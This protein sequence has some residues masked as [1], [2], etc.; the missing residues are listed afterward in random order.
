MRRRRPTSKVR[1]FTKS[2]VRHQLVDVDAGMEIEV[3]LGGVENLDALLTGDAA[4]ALLHVR[5]QGMVAVPFRAPNFEIEIN[6]LSEGQPPVGIP[7]PHEGHV[8]A[9]LVLVVGRQLQGGVEIG[10]RGQGQVERVFLARL[11]QPCQQRLLL[12]D[13]EH[14]VMG[15]EAL[16]VRKEPEILH[17]PHG[18]AHIV[19]AQPLERGN[20]QGRL[21]L[22]QDQVGLECV[23]LGQ[24]GLVKPGSRS[25]AASAPTGRW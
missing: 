2:P 7:C 10:L 21:G 1:G 22:G 11:G 16:P 9:E 6:E 12:D 25:S 17:K 15:R 20:G 18:R 4:A 8:R 13:R 24:H 19:L 3:D 23:H 5:R 14:V